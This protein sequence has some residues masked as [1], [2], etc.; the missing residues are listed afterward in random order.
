MPKYHELPSSKSLSSEANYLYLSG[1]RT[2]LLPFPALSHIK[3]RQVIN[4]K[5]LVRDPLYLV[6]VAKISILPFYILHEFFFRCFSGH[7]LR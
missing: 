3:L 1:R 2:F 5:K 7:S 6:G 4:A